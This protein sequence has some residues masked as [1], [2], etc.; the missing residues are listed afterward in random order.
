MFATPTLADIHATR[1]RL[2]DHI[3]TTPIWHCRGDYLSKKIS[4]TTQVYFKLEFLQYTGS[5]KAR[6]ALNSLAHLTAEQLKRGVVA[7]SAGNHAIAVAYAAKVFGASAK[8]LMPKTASPVRINKCKEYGAIVILVDNIGQA[9]E[10]MPE[11]AREENRAPIHPFEGSFIT[12]ATGTIGVELTEQIPHLD[13]VI[14]PIGGG[15]LIGGI[16]TA[17]K[18]ILPDCQIYGVEPENADVIYQSLLAGKPITIP[19]PQTIADSLSPPIA[20]PYS[21]EL[22][23]R[24][25]NRIVRVSETEMIEAMRLLFYDMKLA[26]EPAA[27]S[28]TAALCHHL[29]LELQD[30]TVA[31]MLSGSNIDTDRFC[32]LIRTPN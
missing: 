20:M 1:Q 9:L 26:V 16:A 21:F 29:A 25:I 14:V 3:V 22:C 28:A 5:F 30:K 2:N 27:A 6:G 23:R 4:P 12:E 17:V 11:I 10:Q 32:R 19:T 18:Q 31:I 24:Y 8:V 15:G 13:A 7:A